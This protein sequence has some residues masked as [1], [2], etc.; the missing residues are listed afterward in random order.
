MTENGRDITIDMAK[1]VGIALVVLGHVSGFGDSVGLVSIRNFLYQFHVPL[2]FFLS[3]YCFKEN[4]GWESFA[5]KRIRRLY[6]PFIIS[7]L[8]FYCIHVFTHTL[9]D[10]T[11]SVIDLVKH[12]IKILLGLDLTPLGGATW[13]LIT[14]L[15]ALVLYKIL[16]TLFNRLPSILVVLSSLLIGITGTLLVLPWGISRA[17]IA[18]FFVCVGH[19]TKRYLD[20]SKMKREIRLLLGLA[21]CG[22]VLACSRISHPDIAFHRFD[23][24]PLFWI[25]ALTGTYVVILLTSFFS[26]FQLLSFLGKWGQ[27]TL[28]ILIGH[29]TAFKIIALTQHWVLRQPLQDTMFAHPCY[30]VGGWWAI[31]YF[32]SGFF[33]PLLIS[34]AFSK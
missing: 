18:L 33:V 28:W 21:G 8:A 25:S 24:L 34:R 19:F 10:E 15:E 31:A 3:G 20:F 23:S 1:T 7:N 26:Q 12:C 6:L 5:I 2:F 27:R 22:L 13:F 14:L 30:Y 29:F 16:I 9:A 32:L 17:L 4:E 11:F